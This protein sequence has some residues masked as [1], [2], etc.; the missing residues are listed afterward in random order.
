MT[1]VALAGGV[2]G[3][4]LAL[5]L[6]RVTGD[7]T[8]IVNTADDFVHLGLHVSPDIDTVTYTLAGIAS[9]ETGWGLK[10]ETWHFLEA[11]GRLG[12]ETWFRLGD[13][14]LATHVERTRRLAAG[15]TLS[16]IT[17][18]FRRRL[19]VAARIVPM[20]DDAVRTTVVTDRGDLPFQDYLVRLRAEPAVAGFRYDGIADARPC[21]AALDALAGASCVIV[22]PSNPFTSIDPIVGIAGLGEALRRRRCPV[23]AVSPLVG[24]Q[25]VKGPLAAMMRTMGLPVSS[26][27]IAAHYGDLIDVLVVDS[28]DAAAAADISGPRVAVGPTVMRSLDDRIVLART[29]L[30]LAQ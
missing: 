5:G 20:S 19:G 11:V 16:A 23:L 7:L 13:R 26:A 9:P 29:V 15:E 30:D 27:G 14:D 8:V 12:G 25:A 18:D 6:A 2:G 1:V 17:D 3:A 28:A 22:C 21:P 4:K 10:D 24:G